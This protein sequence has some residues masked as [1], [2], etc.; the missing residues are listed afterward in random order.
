MNDIIKASPIYHSKQNKA[1]SKPG[2]KLLCPND[3]PSANLSSSIYILLSEFDGRIVSYVPSFF[4][5][6][7][8]GQKRGSITY[9]TDRENEVNKIFII[10]LLCVWRVRE[11]ISIRAEQVQ[12]LANLESKLSQFE[13]LVKWFLSR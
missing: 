12:I 6:N 9:S 5:I 4:P 11:T 7:R 3:S 8:G 10:S 1:K 2:N 13:I